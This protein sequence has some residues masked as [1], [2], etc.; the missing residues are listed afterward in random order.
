MSVESIEQLVSAEVEKRLSKHSVTTESQESMYVVGAKLFIRT[1]SYHYV[2]RVT[3]VGD[4]SVRLSDASWVAD[5]G[6]F[7]AALS[8][9]GLAESD[10]YPDG[11]EVSRSVIVDASPWAHEL[12]KE[13]V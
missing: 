2:G 6:R 5:S 8:A 3:F 7:G 13:S 4:T 1:L 9:G 11:C 10:R 12:P